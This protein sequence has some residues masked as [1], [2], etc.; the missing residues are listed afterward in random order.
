MIMIG[1]SGKNL[2]LDFNGLLYYFY[3][4][5]ILNQFAS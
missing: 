5:Y 2:E 1:Q 3:R 4:H